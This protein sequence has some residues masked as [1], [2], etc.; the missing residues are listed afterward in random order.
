M[1]VNMA[2]LL[3]LVLSNSGK[4]TF[5]R[6]VIFERN[7]IQVRS[8][9]MGPLVSSSTTSLIVEELSQDPDVPVSHFHN[10]S[11]LAL[12]LGQAFFPQ[13]NVKVEKKS[14]PPICADRNRCLPDLH[15]LQ[16]WVIR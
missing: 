15:I 3:F 14:T 9:L 10:E 16:G 7:E 4:S 6:T 2:C 5:V 11:V 8:V 1:N 12:L 13:D